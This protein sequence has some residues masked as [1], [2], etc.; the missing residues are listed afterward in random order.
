MN[1]FNI[2]PNMICALQNVISHTEFCS[3]FYSAIVNLYP[4]PCTLHSLFRKMVRGKRV[5]PEVV[6]AVF[7]LRDEGRSAEEIAATFDHTK[8]WY[9]Y[10]TKEF[11]RITGERWIPEK[12][13]RPR[14]TDLADEATIRGTASALRKKPL[15]A[16][17]KAVRDVGVTACRRTVYNRMREA[18]ITSRPTVLSVLSEVQRECRYA[19]AQRAREIFAVDPLRMNHILFTDEMRGKDPNGMGN[20]PV[21]WSQ[22][23][24]WVG[25]I[26]EQP[27]L[28]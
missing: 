1:R 9:F 19:F 20:D 24:A 4:V 10:I 13:G 21:D 8:R 12:R 17:Y 22:E 18:G 14:A 16:I 28:R 27:R 11:D 15:D 23:T 3:S 5:T 25:R 7:K 26:H 2:D 6:K